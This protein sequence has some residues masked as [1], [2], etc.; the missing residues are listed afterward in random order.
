MI[1]QFGRNEFGD[2][3]IYWRQHGLNISRYY[4][5][6]S[7]REFRNDL[8]KAGFLIVN[9]EGKKIHSKKYPDN[10]FAIIEK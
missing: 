10:Y 2:I 1:S 8:T 9:L 7:K 5:L 6:Y 3:N 4:H